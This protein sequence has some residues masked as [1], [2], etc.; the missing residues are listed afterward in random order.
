[1]IGGISV[2]TQVW[3]Q[4]AETGRRYGVDVDAASATKVQ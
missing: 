2:S 3:E 1:M 4:I